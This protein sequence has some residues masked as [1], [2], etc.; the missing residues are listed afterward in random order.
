MELDQIEQ[1]LA[2]AFK[3]KWISHPFKVNAAAVRISFGNSHRGAYIY[4][5]WYEETRVDRKTFLTL[6][7]PQTECP[8]QRNLLKKWIDRFRSE[9]KSAKPAVRPVI[10]NFSHLAEERWFKYEGQDVM[11]REAKIHKKITC[12]FS[13]H[14]EQT[15]NSPAWD[16]FGT[17][18]R[19]L[20][21]VN[22]ISSTQSK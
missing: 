5:Y 7:C 1:E 13:L 19:Y 12:P 22:H 9:N 20:T 2:E 10:V 11:A 21:T 3:G 15:I 8:N 16:L 14:A 18:G 4:R 6:L 17:D